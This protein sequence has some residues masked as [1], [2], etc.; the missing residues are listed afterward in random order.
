MLYDI[1][2]GKK[3][4]G[5]LLDLLKQNWKPEQYK[6]TLQGLADYCMKN[7]VKPDEK[8][9]TAEPW[10]QEIDSLKAKETA[11]ERAAAD[12]KVHTARMKTVEQVESKL[13]ELCVKAGFDAKE[14]AEEI[15]D[16]IL[17]IT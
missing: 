2:E 13:T 12:E 17:A 10:R 5:E 1:A 6:A 14:D 8:A 15:A 3:H 4:P 11:R 16:Y 9:A 7:G